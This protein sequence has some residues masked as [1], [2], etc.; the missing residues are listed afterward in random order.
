MQDGTTSQVQKCP[1]FQLDPAWNLLASQCKTSPSRLEL[2]TNTWLRAWSPTKFA[3]INT[4][5]YYRY[6][7][8]IMETRNKLYHIVGFDQYNISNDHATT[9]TH[10]NENWL[11]LPPLN[12]LPTKCDKVIAG[13]AGLIFHQHHLVASF[14]FLNF[15]LL[16]FYKV[17][18]NVGGEFP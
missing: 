2:S 12:Y 16:L 8:C 3:N 7:P 9:S 4:R 10:L 18:P 14:H 1:I 15:F 11:A 13:S 6:H 17:S 5:T